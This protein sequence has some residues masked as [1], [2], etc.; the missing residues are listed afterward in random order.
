MERR[1][2]LRGKR[3]LASVA[4]DEFPSG[5]RGSF[6]TVG[7]GILEVA[8]LDE[9]GVETAVG[10]VAEIF[11]KDADKF[12]ADGLAGGVCL[13]RDGGGLRVDRHQGTDQIC[14][15]GEDGQ[16]GAKRAGK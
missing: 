8:V 16:R 2:G 5:Q 15:E 9:R 4:L 14:G 3:T 11:I 7:G 6:G 13:H 1:G 10:G 12:G